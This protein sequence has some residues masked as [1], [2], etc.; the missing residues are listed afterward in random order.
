MY[1]FGDASMTLRTAVR[2]VGA[3][4]EIISPSRSLGSS[5]SCDCDWFSAIL[6]RRPDSD[7]RDI[8]SPRRSCG[9]SSRSEIV[10]M[11]AIFGSYVVF[12]RR[13]AKL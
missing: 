9:R 7:T 3:T 6:M 11:G 13:T 10:L 8:I 4:R 5:S 2:E 1:F 12:N